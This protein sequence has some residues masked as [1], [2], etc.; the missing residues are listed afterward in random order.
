MLDKRW[1]QSTMSCSGCATHSII[2]QGRMDTIGMCAQR[3]TEPSQYKNQFSS[4]QS[5]YHFF[6]NLIGPGR[7]RNKNANRGRDEDDKPLNQNS[8]PPHYQKYCIYLLTL[9]LYRIAKLVGFFFWGGML[10]GFIDW[11]FG[12]IAFFSA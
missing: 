12:W 5:W 7:S 8:L 11:S 6:A 1:H 10:I 4:R 2:L 3:P 9:P